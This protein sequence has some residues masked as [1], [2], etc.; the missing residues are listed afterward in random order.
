[1]IRNKYYLDLKSRARLLYL[2]III[3]D[4]DVN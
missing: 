4:C 1:M 3:N 2:F